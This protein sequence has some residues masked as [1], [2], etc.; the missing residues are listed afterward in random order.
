[1]T[2][3]KRAQHAG[4]T[5]SL[6][7]F[8]R[9]FDLTLLPNDALSPTLQDSPLQLYRGALRDHPNSWARLS[10]RHGQ[11]QGLLWDGQMLYAIEPL[12]HVAPAGTQDTTGTAMFRLADTLLPAALSCGTDIASTALNPGARK[13]SQAYQ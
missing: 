5:L 4:Q 7:A 13:G 11:W 6:Q 3:Q 9:Q 8:G 1:P 10:Q 2:Q 12:A